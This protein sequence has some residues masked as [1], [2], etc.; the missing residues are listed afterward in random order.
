VCCGS[1]PIVCSPSYSGGSSP[2]SICPIFSKLSWKA[3]S[4]LDGSFVLWN[5]PFGD[6]LFSSY[7]KL[8]NIDK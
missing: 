5:T 4:Q 2:S 8:D 7:C 3:V 6:L 1:S